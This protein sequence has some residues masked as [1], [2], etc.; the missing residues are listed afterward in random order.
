VLIDFWA[1]WCVPCRAEN[2]GIVKAVQ[3]LDTH[4]FAALGISL[5]NKKDP[6]LRAIK[7][8]GLNWIQLSDLR[9]WGNNVS[10]KYYVYD[11]PANYLIDPNGVII[12]KNIKADELLPTL[13]KLIK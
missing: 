10:V 13:K 7:Q 2:P 9:L 11:I 6:W 1:S 12:A 5:D 3:Q 4:N 8:D